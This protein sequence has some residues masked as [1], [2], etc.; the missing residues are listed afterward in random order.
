M[1]TLSAS[2]CSSRR[3][4]IGGAS[5]SAATKVYFASGLQLVLAISNNQLAFRD[6]IGHRGKRAARQPDIH[7]SHV[8]SLVRL[9]HNHVVALRAVLNRRRWYCDAALLY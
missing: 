3:S 9:D 1:S 7:H 5:W 6:P 2:R 4:T 8:N